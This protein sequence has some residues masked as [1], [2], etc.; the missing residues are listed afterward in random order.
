MQ[1]VHEIKEQSVSAHI[2][3]DLAIGKAWCAIHMQHMQFLIARH[4][5]AFLQSAHHTIDAPHILCCLSGA[6]LFRVRAE[7]HK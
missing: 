1:K 4:V 6:Y 7:L 2:L 3:H 5:P